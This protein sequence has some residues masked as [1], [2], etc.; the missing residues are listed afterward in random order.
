M[1]FGADVV[2]QAIARE[3]GPVKIDEGHDFD[4]KG[5]VLHFSSEG[6]TFAV[7]VTNEFDA[8]YASGQVRVDLGDLGRVLRASKD[9]R[10]VVMR[11]GIT[12]R[13]AA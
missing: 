8:D 4:T 6:R 12:L 3:F 2:K 13:N 10:A 9:G 5:A 11:S 7:E 1:G